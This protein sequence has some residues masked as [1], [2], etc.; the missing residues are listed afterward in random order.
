MTSWSLVH[1]V[2]LRRTCVFL[3]DCVGSL[4]ISAVRVCRILKNLV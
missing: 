4:E 3:R 2:V 1:R